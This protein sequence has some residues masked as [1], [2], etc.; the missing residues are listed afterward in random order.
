M[1]KCM[2]VV[3]YAQVKLKAK[4]WTKDLL[5]VVI[6]EIMGIKYHRLFNTISNTGPVTVHD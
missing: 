4:M 2:I 3:V 5:W 6:I 1:Q